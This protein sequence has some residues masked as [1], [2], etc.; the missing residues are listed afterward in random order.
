MS[1]RRLSLLAALLPLFYGALFIRTCAYA[2]K[3]SDSLSNM[4]FVEGSGVAEKGAAKGHVPLDVDGYPVAPA[5]LKLQQV[6][7]YVRHGAFTTISKTSSPTNRF[8][9]NR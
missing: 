5:E 2:I 3:T 7:I 9:E 4:G 6:H 1:S 8:R